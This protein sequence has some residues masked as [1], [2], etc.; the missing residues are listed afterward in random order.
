MSYLKQILSQKANQI[1]RS[2]RSCYAG[3]HLGQPVKGLHKTG[4]HVKVYAATVKKRFAGIGFLQIEIER[5]CN[6]KTL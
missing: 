3:I 2:K 5:R 4:G 6:I 1:T